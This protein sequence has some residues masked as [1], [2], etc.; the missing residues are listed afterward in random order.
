MLRVRDGANVRKGRTSTYRLGCVWQFARSTAQAEVRAEV[1]ARLYLKG[2]WRSL[3]PQSALPTTLLPDRQSKIDSGLVGRAEDWC[4]GPKRSKSRER[5]FRRGRAGW[6]LVCG[7]GGFGWAT[8]SLAHRCLSR[9]GLQPWAMRQTRT[10]E[11]ECTQASSSQPPA[12]PP[13][14]FLDCFAVLWAAALD[15]S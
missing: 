7:T 8:R 3:G 13:R 10:N 6:V 2:G 12:W 11:Y 9:A 1:Q 15:S 14:G 5:P 4:G